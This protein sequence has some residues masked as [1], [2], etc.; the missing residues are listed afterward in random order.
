M[1]LPS[2]C[3]CRPTKVAIVEGVA[4]SNKKEAKI[5]QNMESVVFLYLLFKKVTKTYYES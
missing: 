1:L 4:F 3:V 2:S 5:K